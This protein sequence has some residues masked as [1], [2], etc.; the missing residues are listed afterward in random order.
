LLTIHLQ[1]DFFYP[2][3][4]NQ[5][6]LRS[7]NI[8]FP[9]CNLTF[10]IGKSGSGKSTIGQLLVR[11]YDYNQNGGGIVAD[12]YNLHE[13]DPA[14]LRQKILLVEQESILFQGTIY[15][16]IAYGCIDREVSL[17]EV[18]KAAEFANILDTIKLMP[19]GFDTQVG[20]KGMLLSGGQ[21]QRIALARAFLRDP[22]V[23][24]LDE[25]TSALD[26]QNR[27]AIMEK[28]RS[29]RYGKTTIV[30]THDISQILAGDTIY[31]MK[32]GQVVDHG[33]RFYLEAK[34]N[35]AFRQFRHSSI[36]SSANSR[37]SPNLNNPLPPLPDS[38][39]DEG[40]P[41]SPSG[42]PLPDDP[43]EDFDDPLLDYL[44]RFCDEDT[45][46]YSIVSPTLRG[47]SSTMTFRQ[48]M[49][50][51]PRLSIIA[52][53]STFR[54]PSHSGS[55]SSTSAIERQVSPPIQ[56]DLDRFNP[57]RPAPAL[58]TVPS[59]VVL[60]SARVRQDLT[61]AVQ[62]PR[63]SMTESIL[64]RTI[65]EIGGDAIPLQSL[66]SERQGNINK[67]V[68]VE[69]PKK[70]KTL[71]IWRILSTVWP[72]F[73]W[74]LRRQLL[75]A[76]LGA[77]GYAVATPMFGF[78]FS[79]LLASLYEPVG[80][81]FMSGILSLIIL[82][83]AFTDGICVFVQQSRFERCAL[84]WVNVMRSKAYRR[85][86]LQ[87]REFF[88]REENGVSRLMDH[89]DVD[90]EQ[91]Q[92]LL[93]RFIGYL[94]I[95]SAMVTICI[96]WSLTSCWKLTLVL[97][98]C[99]PIIIGLSALFARINSIYERLIASRSDHAASIFMDCFANIKTVRTLSAES[100]IEKKYMAASSEIFINGFK[101]ALYCGL[102]Y[103][104]SQASMIAV[105]TLTFYF[106]LRLLAHGEYTL[107]RVIE[108][109]SILLWTV[110]NA[111]NI[112]A[113]IPRG[114][115]AQEAAT[116]LLR[117]VNLPLNSFE[118]NGKIRIDKVG[119]IKFSSVNFVYPTRPTKLVLQKLSLSIDE[120]EC[121]AIVGSSGSGKST[122]ASLLLKLYPT[123]QFDVPF[124]SIYL[125]GR[126]INTIHTS[127]L[128]SL[129]TVV[130]QTPMIFPAT[131]RENIVYGLPAGS[132]LAQ[133]NSVQ[134]AAKSAGIEDFILSLPQGYDTLIGEGGLGV[135]GGQAQRIAIARALVRKPHILILDE[136]TSAL[137]VE[138]A[139]TIRETIISLLHENRRSPTGFVDVPLDSS[140]PQ[141]SPLTV[142]IITHNKEM[143]NFADK[144]AM[145]HEGRIVEEGPYNELL[146]KR[147]GPFSKM[148]RGEDFAKDTESV[149]RR[150]WTAMNSSPGII[151]SPWTNQP[152][153]SRRPDTG[154][155]K[156]AVRDV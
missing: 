78:V 61:L 77:I 144:V 119:A 88:D 47:R 113:F 14:W 148:M 108:V 155:G 152:S 27:G 100:K 140:T 56:A 31:I 105:I 146:R 25:S 4:P 147:N 132:N 12:G 117:L 150:S 138:S 49:L 91:M 58:P 153:S 156:Q 15:E 53:P 46:R 30:I 96:I 19:D 5:A 94:F 137:D 139:R 82:F 130:P 87:P 142:I 37:L 44:K 52:G 40:G 70:E 59:E 79:K 131:V 36:G 128:R 143:M 115:A 106:A 135:S 13:L 116:R 64:Q 103:G 125:N 84:A 72:G 1:V 71:S 133:A 7:L 121:V 110:P 17:Q 74:K 33:K 63:E 81:S 114:S 24:I 11:L 134:R 151:S 122:I 69:Q 107:G 39:L 86:L 76:L 54:E 97:L 95:A 60:R 23:L 127:T 83:I 22:P 104:T 101:K 68:E 80:R 73:A 109:L 9:A 43:D 6:I 66:S 55:Q 149:N 111:A 38:P 20:S 75:F 3:R 141:P 41:S 34:P 124:G 92:S 129:A 154:K 85:V 8:E 112:F 18:E 57:E 120:G 29:W 67:V 10:V 98:A 48:S 123:R 32:D 65:R 62:S 35:S 28:I 51:R 126:D 89:F 90:A 136:A 145:L 26:Y 93:G 42:I 118:L 99:T 102:A 16:N 2:N 45:Q 21:R 50:P